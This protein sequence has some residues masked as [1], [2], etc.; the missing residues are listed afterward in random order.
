MT[1]DLIGDLMARI[2]AALEAWKFEIDETNTVSV[3]ASIGYATY[4]EDGRTLPELMQAA[5][6]RLRHNKA[7]RQLRSQA[8][9]AGNLRFFPGVKQEITG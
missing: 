7:A 6:Q 9:A 3:E 2:H 8:Q 1:P 4:G 5:D